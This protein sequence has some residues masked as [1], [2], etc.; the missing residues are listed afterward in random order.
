MTGRCRQAAGP[1]TRIL[2]SGLRSRLRQAHARS[3]GRPVVGLGAASSGPDWRS[4]RDVLS[5]A[6]FASALVSKH[7]SPLVNAYVGSALLQAPPFRAGV[8]DRRV[9]PRSVVYLHDDTSVTGT[10]S[11]IR[12]PRTTAWSPIYREHR[13]ARNPARQVSGVSFRPSFVLWPSSYFF[14]KAA[15]R[16][17]RRW[18]SVSSRDWLCFRRTLAPRAALPLGRRAGQ[19]L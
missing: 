11:V 12:F 2:S 1:V 8:V 5:V 10:E 7:Q 3:V 18:I 19:N 9:R 17:S 15:G 4:I 13:S 14:R 6:R 16:S